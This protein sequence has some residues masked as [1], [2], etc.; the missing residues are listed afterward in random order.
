VKWDSLFYRFFFNWQFSFH[1]SYA[2]CSEICYC[3]KLLQI[4]RL[5]VQYSSV[6]LSSIMYRYSLKAVVLSFCESKIMH[7]AN[8]TISK[9]E[10]IMK[11]AHDNSHSITHV[12]STTATSLINSYK[13]SYSKGIAHQ[14]CWMTLK[15]HLQSSE[16][17]RFDW[18]HWFP[19]VMISYVDKSASFASNCQRALASIDREKQIWLKWYMHA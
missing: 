5:S 17:T 13:F 19:L 3:Q 4:K 10:F 2:L 14:H 8:I 9:L 12:N 16:V 11:Y 15:G 6:S 7:I 18:L 1:A